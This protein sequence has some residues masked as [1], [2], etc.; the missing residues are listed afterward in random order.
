MIQTRQMMVVIDIL[1]LPVG[2]VRKRD[3]LLRIVQIR[4]MHPK[5]GGETNKDSK[6]TEQTSPYKIPP[7]E[8]NPR[9]RR[10]MTLSV[11]GANDANNGQR[12]RRSILWHSTRQRPS[13]NIQHKQIWQ[14]MYL[15]LAYRCHIFSKWA[16]IFGLIVC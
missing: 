4:S 1:I 5:K 15:S 14:V 6:K 13:C 3:T 11:H 7:K 9:P 16:Y 8:N 12:V 10:S 2:S